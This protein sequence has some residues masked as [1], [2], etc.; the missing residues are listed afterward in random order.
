MTNHIVDR[1]LTEPLIRAN[2]AAIDRVTMV[3]QI[4]SDALA[5]LPP[6]PMLDRDVDAMLDARD[7]L[8]HSIRVA[9]QHQANLA[10]IVKFYLSTY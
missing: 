9:N 1:L 7:T 4:A 6:M 3:A 2:L 10:R 8:Y 5:E